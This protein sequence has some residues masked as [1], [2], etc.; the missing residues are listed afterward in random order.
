MKTF[1]R[2]LTR[3]WNANPDTAGM[4][5]SNGYIAGQKVLDKLIAAVEGYGKTKGW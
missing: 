5:G 3:K 4:A 2:E 1:D